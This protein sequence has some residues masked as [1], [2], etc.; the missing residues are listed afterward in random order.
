MLV[1]VGALIGGMVLTT[2]CIAVMNKILDD[3][4]FAFWRN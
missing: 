1:F 2:L 4:W 3:D